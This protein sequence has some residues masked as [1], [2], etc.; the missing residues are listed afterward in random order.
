MI[1]SRLS[2]NASVWR[3]TRGLR[4]DGVHNY[5]SRL[6]DL[7]IGKQNFANRAD[8]PSTAPCA[9][10]SLGRARATRRDETRRGDAPAATG[11]KKPRSDARAVVRASVRPR[12]GNAA[13]TR[14][15]GAA[16]RVATRR[17][18]DARAGNATRDF[19]GFRC[20]YIIHTSGIKYQK[21][22]VR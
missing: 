20:T 16:R 3:R 13:G 18:G 9:P 17:G 14:G 1:Q 2:R 10:L 11:D 15:G 7:Q 4:V 6:A 5:E 12:G 19:A 21:C 22:I 8:A